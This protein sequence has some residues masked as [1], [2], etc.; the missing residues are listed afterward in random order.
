VPRMSVVSGF[1]ILSTADLPRL[2]AFYE[3]AFLGVVGYR[4]AHEGTDVYVAMKIGAA[5]LGIGW[6]PDADDSDHDRVALWFYVDDLD[7]AFARARAAGGRVVEDPEVRPWGE[8]V[9]SLRDP[10]GTLVNVATPPD[11]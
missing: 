1:P 11:P 3:N 5:S 7:A 9:G 8:R 2:V 10:S 6:E 4:F